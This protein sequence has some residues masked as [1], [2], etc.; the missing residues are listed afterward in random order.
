M[1]E[2]VGQVIELA[3]DPEKPQSKEYVRDRILFDVS[4]PLR[5]SKEVQLPDGSI[6]S[7]RFDYERV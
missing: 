6:T 5:N 2:C 4:K 1:A 7:I 3:F